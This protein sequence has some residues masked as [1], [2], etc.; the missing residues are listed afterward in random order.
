MKP[1][2]PA[3]PSRA[4]RFLQAARLHQPDTPSRYV[5]DYMDHA[6]V[7]QGPIFAQGLFRPTQNGAPAVPIEVLFASKV[8]GSSMRYLLDSPEALNITDQAVYFYLCQRVGAGKCVP[9]SHEHDSFEAYRETLGVKGPWEKKTM[10][11]IIATPSDIA[12]GIGL[13]RTGTNAKAML[14]SLNRLSQVSMQVRMWDNKGTTVVQ[15]ASRFLGFLCYDNQV[16]IVLHYE[17]TLLAG[18]RKSVAWINMREHRVLRT[19]PAKRLHAWLSGW[20]SAGSRKLVGLDSLLVNVWGEKPAT[21]AIRKDRKRTLRQAI[22]EVSHL[23]GWTCVYTDKGDQLIVARPAFEGTK[24][25]RGKQPPKHRKETA[26]TAATPTNRAETPTQVAT[27]PTKV[28]AT[29]TAD[30]LEPACSADSN[31]LFFAL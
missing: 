12:A 20:A 26:P 2:K 8:D 9:L 29:P 10:S 22:A 5:V 11:V 18:H 14:A 23:E 21:P 6:P 30:L 27:T 28:V 16:G 17:S 7:W 31:E 15:G 25:Q 4:G 3:K 24:A 13:T 1:S 19:K